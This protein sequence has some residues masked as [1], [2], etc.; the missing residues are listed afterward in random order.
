VRTGD[1]ETVVNVA[2]GQQNIGVYLAD[3]FEII[4]QLGS[5]WRADSST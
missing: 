4:P 1:F 5:P 3:T 2:T